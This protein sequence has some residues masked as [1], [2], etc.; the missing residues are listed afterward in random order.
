MPVEVISINPKEIFCPTKQSAVEIDLSKGVYP[1]EAQPV[2]G[3]LLARQLK[4]GPVDPLP[5]AH[6]LDT[7]LVR[8]DEGVRYHPLPEQVSL[9]HRGDLHCDRGGVGLSLLRQVEVAQDDLS[10]ERRQ[11][12]EQREGKESSSD[13]HRDDE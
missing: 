5:I 9:H 13:K 12:G 10:G 8:T 2:A 3:E 1:P 11:E 4:G 7:V 6:P